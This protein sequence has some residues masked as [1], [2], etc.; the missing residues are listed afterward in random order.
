MLSTKIKAFGLSLAMIA[1]SLLPQF[2]LAANLNDAMGT[3]SNAGN[4]AGTGDAEVE[5]VVGSIINAAL[6]M[7][8]LIFLVLMIYGGFLWMTARGDESAIEKAQKIISA[9]VVGL[10]VIMA[11][12]AI[13]FF[14]TSRLESAA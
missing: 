2:L 1:L 14:V 9:A 3:L 7:V 4:K 8:G 12:Y 5:N 10:V 11:A 13:T 6:S